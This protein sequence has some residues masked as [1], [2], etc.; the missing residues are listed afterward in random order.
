MT[1]V[2][3]IVLAA[4]SDLARGLQAL[5]VRFCIIGALVPVVLLG[6]APRRRTNDADATIIVGSLEDFDRLKRQLVEFG[7]GPTPRRYR[8]AHGAG[9]RVDLIPYSATLAPNGHLELGDEV[10][11]NLAGFELV[12]PNAVD[13]PIGPGRPSRA[14]ET[15]RVR[16]PESAEGSRQRVPLPAALP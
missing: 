4:L 14:P 6:A 16:G 13:V 15:R 2:D 3:P 5:Q 10:T 1:S 7:F 8:I 11:F 9:G 12:V